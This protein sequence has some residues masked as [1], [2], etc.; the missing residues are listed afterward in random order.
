[1]YDQDSRKTIPFGAAYIYIAHIREYSPS[2]RNIPPPKTGSFICSCN[3]GLT[4]RIHAIFSKNGR[5]S[6]KSLTIEIFHPRKVI[7][8]FAE[9]QMQCLLAII[10]GK[11]S[12]ILYLPFATIYK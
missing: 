3:L 4:K 8:K 9:C 1:M 6:K 10:V 7:T 11:D 12:T 5:I 2:G